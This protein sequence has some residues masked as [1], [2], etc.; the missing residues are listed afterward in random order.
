MMK[1]LF[2]ALV[3]LIIIGVSSCAEDTEFP[4]DQDELEKFIGIW[5]VSD[6]ALKI[7]YEVNIER[8]AT[9]TSKV[10]L[11]NFAG[12]GDA[13]EGLVAG[14]SIVISYQEVGQSWYV[15]GTGTYVSDSR[16]DFNYTLDIGGNEEERRAVFTK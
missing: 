9:N 7:N 4:I 5:S 8:S 3:L 6:N 15:N 13:A 2:R 1:I 11:N 16:L 14:K 10:I 12:S